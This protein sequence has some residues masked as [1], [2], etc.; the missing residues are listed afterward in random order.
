[1]IANLF[2]DGL[3]EPDRLISRYIAAYFDLLISSISQYDLEVAQVEGRNII[4]KVPTHMQDP[5]A[6]TRQ[7]EDKS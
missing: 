1:M 5:Q 7:R 2:L 6:Y 3:A 4:R